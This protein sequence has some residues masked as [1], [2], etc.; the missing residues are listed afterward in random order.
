MA[1]GNS[2]SMS[3]TNPSA[4]GYGEWSKYR[5]EL[6]DKANAEHPDAGPART[7][8]FAAINKIEDARD[9]FQREKEK[10]EK[11]QRKKDREEGKNAKEKEKNRVEGLAKALITEMDPYEKALAQRMYE[12]EKAEQKYYD[13][14]LGPVKGFAHNAKPNEKGLPDGYSAIKGAFRES[15]YKLGGG[16]VEGVLDAYATDSNQLSKWWKRDQAAEE[17]EAKRLAAAGEDV[18]TTGIYSSKAYFV[19]RPVTKNVYD[20]ATKEWVDKTSMA[21]VRIEKYSKS[22]YRQDAGLRKD[23]EQRAQEVIHSYANKLIVKTEEIAGKGV[24]LVGAP[25]IKLTGNDPWRDSEMEIGMGD[26]KVTWKTKM[27]WNTVGRGIN[28][29]NSYNQWPTRLKDTS[30]I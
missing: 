9:K 19:M 16:K 15:Y 17:V 10:A 2:R 30:Q 14:R 27:I 13:D 8:A 20:D 26:K 18:I 12:N 3:E 28:E 24:G 1:R 11:A 4:M 22:A 6:Y 29:G 25:K 7:A 21:P 23:A 5:K